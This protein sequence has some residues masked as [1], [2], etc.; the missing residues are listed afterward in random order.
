MDEE[1]VIHL[2]ENPIEHGNFR[3]KNAPGQKIRPTLVDR[4]N[5]LVTKVNLLGITHGEMAGGDDLATLLVFE[6]RF[7]PT[8]GRRFKNAEVTIRFEDSGGKMHLDPVVHSIAPE[9]KWALNKSEKVQNIRLSSNASI[10]ARLGLAGAEAGV[11]WEF[12]E[13]RNCEYYASLSGSKRIARDG[14]VGEADTVVWTLDENKHKKDGI[15]T[16][17]RAAVLLKRPGNVPFTFT[18]E[19]SADVDFAGKIKALIGLEKK[20]PIDPVE[21]DPENSTKAR[22]LQFNAL[23]PDTYDL[24]EM[25]KLDLQEVAGVTVVTVLDG[26]SIAQ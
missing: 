22:H 16:F 3:T 20:D 26:G 21:I 11:K 2:F 12:A 7:V 10:N 17:M 24:T 13:T 5:Q 18:V 14:S 4:G 8:G 19:V 6:F 9:G 25:D 15:P 23:D 1:L